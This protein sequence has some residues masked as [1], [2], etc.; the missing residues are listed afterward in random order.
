MYGAEVSVFH[1]TYYICFCSLLQAYD[2]APL[3]AQ[4]I[5]ANLKGY[6]K[7]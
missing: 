4:I 3:E 2:S 1:E 6:L 5:L 7:N